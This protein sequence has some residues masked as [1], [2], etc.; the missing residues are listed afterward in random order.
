MF[1]KQLGGGAPGFSSR[2]TC[3]LTVPLLPSLPSFFDRA[4]LSKLG[5]K[6]KIQLKRKAAHKEVRAYGIKGAEAKEKECK[7]RGRT[8][9]SKR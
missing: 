2:G 5:G 7:I 3:T 8:K 6:G 4:T 1:S 9:R